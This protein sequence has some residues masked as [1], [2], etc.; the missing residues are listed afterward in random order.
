MQRSILLGLVLLLVS[1]VI[2]AQ[3]DVPAI[4]GVRD[5]QVVVVNDSETIIFDSAVE[6]VYLLDANSQGDVLFMDVRRTVIYEGALYL[7]DGAE[8]RII[9][10]D[11]IGNCPAYFTGDGHVVYVGNEYLERDD[12]MKAIVPVIQHNYLTGESEQIATLEVPTIG[13]GGGGSGYLMDHIY[14]AE[15]FSNGWGAT[16]NL[17]QVNEPSVLAGH[18]LCGSGIRQWNG[19]TDFA[20]STADHVA[21]SRDASR[22]VT[23]DY[24][25]ESDTNSVQVIDIA[26]GDSTPIDLTDYPATVSSVHLAANGMIYLAGYR[27]IEP[28]LSLSDLQDNTMA[29]LEEYGWYQWDTTHHVFIYQIDPE[30]GEISLFYEAFNEWVIARLSDAH[31]YLYWSQIPDG[32]PVFDAIDAGE[33]D[34]SYSGDMVQD[35]LLPDVYRQSLTDGEAELVAENLQ[36]FI[37]VPTS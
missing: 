3:D 36:R 24:S 35:Y 12:D 22:I 21:L 34:S 5:N 14:V 32:T 25:F 19:E 27:L 8:S 7:Y 37:P 33:I 11:F 9:T 16:S 28:A 30:S 20:V 6:T 1:G 18:G 23:V 2:I 10:E 4:I 31:G 17:L 13:G 29:S 26:T 15:Y